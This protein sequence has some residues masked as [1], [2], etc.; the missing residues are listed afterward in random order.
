MNGVLV[1]SLVPMLNAGIGINYGLSIGVLAGLL[2]MCIA[3]NFHLG[4]IAG[5]AVA[6]ILA[7]VFSLPS[8]YGY[9]KILNRV[10]GQ[11]EITALFFGSAVVFAMSFFWAVAP[12]TNTEMLWPIGGSGLRHTIGLQST[13]SHVLNNFAAFS[14]GGV[15]IPAGGILFFGIICLFLWIFPRTKIGWAMAV[16]GENELFAAASGID[17]NRYRTLAVMLSTA[18]GSVGI[19][20]WAQ[21]Y[22]FIELYGSADMMAFPAASSIL[23][24]GSMGKRANTLH[25]ILGTFLF[26][27]VYIFSSPLANTFVIPEMSEII[28]VIV[29]NGIILYAV[30][31]QAGRKN[32]VKTN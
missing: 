23:L 19:C 16:V 6:V 18:L 31:F 5:F 27:T 28:R 29:T 10:R 22:G 26:Q 3:I 14:I 17:V 24:G 1:L 20:V 15:T 4:G 12:F 8:G 30:F 13:F 25:V 21:S 11:E 2:G 32:V 7:I 9:G